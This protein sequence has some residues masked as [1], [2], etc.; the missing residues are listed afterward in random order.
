M[1]FQV[2]FYYQIIIICISAFVTWPW[3][4]N[5][6]N[7]SSPLG[8]NSVGTFTV[9]QPLT[10]SQ[11][12]Q[13]SADLNYYVQLSAGRANGWYVRWTG[14]QCQSPD[15]NRI[16]SKQIMGSILVSFIILLRIWV[17]ISI[18]LSHSVSVP[19]S[20]LISELPNLDQEQNFTELNGHWST[21]STRNW[22][23]CSVHALYFSCLIRWLLLLLYYYTLSNPPQ[24]QPHQCPVQ[25]S[26]CDR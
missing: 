13:S 10:P 24:S 2:R 16:Q 4:T 14:E 19:A 25:V 26:V 20:V 18:G 7:A 11:S 15:P 23:L 22:L 8:Y 6:S 1:E 12:I 9:T 5:K 21:C 17:P 3:H